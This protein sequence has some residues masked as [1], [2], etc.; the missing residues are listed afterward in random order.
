[1]RVSQWICNRYSIS[2]LDG[3]NLH[4]MPVGDH[5]LSNEDEKTQDPS[6]SDIKKRGES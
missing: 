3:S 4:A 1:M 6:K 5:T 2:C